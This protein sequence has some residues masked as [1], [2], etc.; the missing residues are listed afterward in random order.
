MISCHV[1]FVPFVRTVLIRLC[2]PC[3]ERGVDMTVEARLERIED[4]VSRVLELFDQMQA[5]N[6]HQLVAVQVII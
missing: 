4:M 1:V 6:E 2:G 3:A 5:H